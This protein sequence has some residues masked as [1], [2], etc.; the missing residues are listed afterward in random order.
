MPNP[1]DPFRTNVL[2]DRHRDRWQLELDVSEFTLDVVRG[3]AYLD[4]FS[5]AEHEADYA[6]RLSM[7]C[8][9]DMCRDGVR[10][11]VDN[12]WRTPP[13]RVIR[14]GPHAELL[15]RLVHD[16]D[17]EGTPLDAFMRQACWDM[18]VA[19]T[20]IVAQMSAPGAALPRT[21]ADERAAGLRPYFLRFSPLQRPDWAVSGTGQFAWA[22][23]CLGA[24][25]PAD[26]RDDAGPPEVRFLTVG[27]DCWRL[28]AARAAGAGAAPS[29]RL[30]GEGDNPLGRPP[31]VKLYFSESRKPGQGGVPLSLLTR[32][33]LV[34]RVAMN[35]KSQADADLLAAVTRWTLSGAG[36]DDLPDSYA[37]GVVWKLPN[38]EARLQ[39]AQGDVAH[40]AE[41]RQWLVLY[42]A[43][44]LRLLKFR[45][46]MA[47]IEAGTGS[48]LRL[49]LER[50]DLDNELRATAG[51]LEAAE[52]EMMR[53]AVSLAGGAAIPAE[54]AG[55]E[56]GYAVTYNRDFVLAPV[57]EML[58][59]IGRWL[60]DCSA[61]AGDVKEISREL[62]RQLA[63]LLMRD[64]T[65][66]YRTTM[67]QID[68]APLS[69]P[70]EVE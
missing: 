32:P 7:A 46:G 48:G 40:I 62:T 64:G 57:A 61:V 56:L 33:A 49:A 44:I 53:Q 30:L 60:R 14:E 6:Y 24:D 29:V 55:Q 25:S 11:R 52:L 67:E 20:D 16:A 41:K 15:R 47:E 13:K 9:L 34:A 36:A 35:L 18:Y 26:E 63:N 12:L 19:G 70:G 22:R 45:G 68:E 5:D 65:D 31:V 8:P 50:T 38:P 3:G 4:R 37:P 10:I 17:G 28:W 66:A 54:Q 59:N 2:F 58:E 51:Q 43:E 21:R 23:Y 27:G 39:I 42:L 69:N 1:F